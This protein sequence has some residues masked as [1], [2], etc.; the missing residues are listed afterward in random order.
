MMKNINLSLLSLMG[1]ISLVGCS[2]A[3][4]YHHSER[5]SI[6]IESR[7]TD[8]Q[9][10]LQGTIGVKT[11]TVV[12]TPKNNKSTGNA[13]SVV[14]DFKLSRESSDDWYKFGTT[15]I[16]SSFMT[17]QAAIDASTDT[18]LAVKDL[19]SGSLGELNARR[20]MLINNIYSTLSTVQDKKA[21][22]ISA[23]LDK[24]NNL[25]PDVSKM[26]FYYIDTDANGKVKDNI[27]DKSV[28]KLLPGFNGVQEYLNLIE[29][30]ITALDTMKHNRAFTY[31]DNLID[32]AQ[33]TLLEQAKDTLINEREVFART[34][35]NSPQI[36]DA[37][38]YVLGLL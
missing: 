9:Q 27:T 17:G 35:G 24:L 37:A 18:V 36:D 6:A 28:I 14:S 12:V 7:T 11:R 15:T 19:A 23:D 38:A 1:L 5:N 20:K 8:P 26:A 4:T 33:F 29:N 34:I 21:L 22:S 13:T 32:Q 16:N 31:N 25:L 3:V 10:P 2:N 30:S